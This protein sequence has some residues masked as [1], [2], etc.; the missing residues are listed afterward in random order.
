MSKSNRDGKHR[1]AIAIAKSRENFTCELCPNDM[2]LH[3]HHVIDL[4][5]G[6]EA[7]QQ[8]II[9]VCKPCHDKI[10]NGEINIHT[11]DFR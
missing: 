4:G 6:G 11:F 10:H 7:E 2:N 8:N 5:F 9:V 3:G 1:R